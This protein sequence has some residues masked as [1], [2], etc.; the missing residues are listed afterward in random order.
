MAKVIVYEKGDLLFIYNFHP[1][2]SLQDYAIGTKWQSDH[3]ILFE[4]D[5]DSFGGHR[6]LDGAHS[7]W[8]EVHPYE[9][10][11]RPNHFKFYVP[12]RSCIVMCAYENAAKIL[13]TN[14]NAIA[15]MPQ[16][17]DRQK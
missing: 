5:E 14:P 17:T 8:F 6:R 11:K 12:C 7:M 9:C 1:T 2:N 3:F 10:N 16:V 4:S 13:E 15:R